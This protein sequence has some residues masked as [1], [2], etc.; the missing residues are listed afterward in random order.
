MD[1]ASDN[2]NFSQFFFS[3]KTFNLLKKVSFPSRLLYCVGWT[4]KDWLHLYGLCTFN[5]RI[6]AIYTELHRNSVSKPGKLS[7]DPSLIKVRLQISQKER[8]ITYWAT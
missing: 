3:T 7:W 2:L 4:G 1:I 8:V 6:K 5:V